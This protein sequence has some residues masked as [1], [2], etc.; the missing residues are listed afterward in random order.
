MYQA[1]MIVMSD[2][3][4]EKYTYLVYSNSNV[5]KHTEHTEYTYTY[6]KYCIPKLTIINNNIQHL[7]ID[8]CNT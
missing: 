7:D 6:A 4:D 2:V 3:C 8:I 1:K 5:H